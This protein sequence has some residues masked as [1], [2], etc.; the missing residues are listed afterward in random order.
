MTIYDSD[1]SEI[2]RG[3]LI[4]MTMLC[5]TVPELQVNLFRISM[6]KG[7]DLYDSGLKGTF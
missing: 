4:N 3:E 2:L 5:S 6:A 1:D 7:L